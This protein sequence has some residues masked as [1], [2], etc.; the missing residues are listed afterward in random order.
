VCFNC[1]VGDRWQMACAAGLVFLRALAPMDCAW[2][3]DTLQSSSTFYR[4]EAVVYVLAPAVAQQFPGLGLS[5]RGHICI[6]RSRLIVGGA[7]PR[8]PLNLSQVGEWPLSNFAPPS[9]GCR[10]FDGEWEC[11]KCHHMN[12]V[13]GRCVNCRGIAPPCRWV[14]APRAQA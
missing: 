3:G 4:R 2:P 9:C 10:R 13:D 14:M 11:G 8:T 1:A 6:I 7:A 12:P 5:L